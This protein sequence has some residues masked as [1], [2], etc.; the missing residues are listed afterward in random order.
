MKNRNPRKTVLT[1]SWS[2]IE[3]Q[4]VLSKDP[5]DREEEKNSWQD[6]SFWERVNNHQKKC[7]LLITPTHRPDFARLR[8]TSLNKVRNTRTRK[9]DPKTSTLLSGGAGIVDCPLHH[10]IRLS[11][12]LEASPYNQ[13][14]SVAYFYFGV[15]YTPCTAAPLNS[16][17]I[18]WNK[19]YYD[20]I[21]CDITVQKTHRTF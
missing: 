20:D 5:Q 9:K 15:F 17:G 21:V 8:E 7:I 1:E 18:K 10:Q 12:I 16:T 19:S 13:P 11:F 4:S 2:E 3:N 14:Y 6:F